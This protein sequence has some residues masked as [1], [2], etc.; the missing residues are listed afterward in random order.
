M[1]SAGR[2]LSTGGDWESD[3]VDAGDTIALEHSFGVYEIEIR[4]RENFGPWSEW[5]PAVE[6]TASPFAED[7]ATREIDEDAPA[8]SNVG[9]PVVIAAQGYVAAYSIPDNHRYFSIDSASGQITLKG[10]TPSP[11]DYPVVV[12]A[13][14]SK[15][16]VMSQ[17]AANVTINVTSMD[18]W[19]QLAIQRADDGGRRRQLWQFHRG[20]RGHRSF[21][22]RRPRS[23]Q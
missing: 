6:V 4:G 15:G 10:M 7:S 17:A 14:L 18:P 16:G 1:R 5:S 11:D 2:N 20:G 13:T 3:R 9:K 23:G 8:G 22:N 19:V 21:G 12:T